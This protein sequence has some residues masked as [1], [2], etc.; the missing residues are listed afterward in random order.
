VSVAA[1]TRWANPFRPAARTPEANHAAV[2]HFTAYLRR[3]PAL[4][5]EAVAAL[6]GRNLACW[7]AP[8]LACHAD[9]WL[10]LVNESAGTNHG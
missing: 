6:R 7:C 4:V 2:E 8:H 3:N 1:P 10:A 5:E 9:V